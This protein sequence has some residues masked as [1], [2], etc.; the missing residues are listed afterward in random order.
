M[1]VESM[2]LPKYACEVATGGTAWFAGVSAVIWYP[3]A[4]LYAYHSALGHLPPF[5]DRAFGAYAV[6]GVLVLGLAHAFTSRRRMPAQSSR[7]VVGFALFVAV[8]ASWSLVHFMFG[9]GVRGSRDLLLYNGRILLNYCFL[10][11]VGF[12]LRPERW[13]ALFFV[14][15][16]ALATNAVVYTRWDRMMV[17]LRGVIDARYAGIYLSLSATA[18][19]ASLFTWAAVRRP[20]MRAAVLIGTLPVLFLMGGRADLA[21]FVLVFP[22][23]LWLTLSGSGRA[24]VY[25]SL[26]ALAG[27][28]VS[29]GIEALHMSRHAQFLSLGEMTS[30]IART[31]LLEAGMERIAMS[32]LFGDYGGTLIVYGSIG[33][34]IHNMLSVWQSFGL[35]P[36]VIYAWLL[37]CSALASIGLLLHR[38]R[39]MSREAQL[40][41]VLCL[42]AVIQVLVAKSFGWAEVALAWGAMAGVMS[43]RLP[44]SL[45]PVPSTV[46]RLRLA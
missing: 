17:D 7:M 2:R 23:A 15:F 27:I 10:F 34:Y 38:G 16:V 9:E 26:A 35:L 20:A 30:L 11:L 36:F 6:L 42:V 5:L 44:P 33:S 4:H 39:R 3:L 37:G 43:R 21:A 24:V 1:R 41:V 22:V 45:S 8:T 14:G 13:R 46:D 18:L 40:A 28:V 25:I 29:L 31:D 32:P 19:F 12:Y